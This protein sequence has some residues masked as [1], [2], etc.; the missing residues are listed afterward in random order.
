MQA[1]SRDRSKLS[2]RLIASSLVKERV[3]SSI[4]ESVCLDRIRH[5]GA[6]GI[7]R[8]VI[9]RWTSEGNNG[10][11]RLKKGTSQSASQT[12]C[13]SSITTSRGFPA[14]LSSS[15]T[16]ASAT[17]GIRSGVALHSKGKRA[18]PNPSRCLEILAIKYWKKIRSS[19]SGAS[20][21]YQAT[22][23][24]EFSAKSIARL[25]LP[26]PARPLRIVEVQEDKLC[27]RM[28]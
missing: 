9:N 19:L 1:C 16:K 18:P 24:P 4:T 22:D 3:S 13:K 12:R 2:N 5:K 26:V 17:N 28:V 11:K 25:V 20:T 7:V 8:L 10:S 14:S 15:Y 6:G 23:L 27:S 21:L